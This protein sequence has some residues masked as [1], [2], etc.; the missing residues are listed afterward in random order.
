MQLRTRTLSMAALFLVT[1]CGGTTEESMHEEPSQMGLHTA[2]LELPGEAEAQ[3][4]LPTQSVLAHGCQ[5]TLEMARGFP[6]FLR[7]LIL[8]RRASPHCVAETVTLVE[9][10]PFLLPGGLVLAEK[11]NELVV[12]YRRIL[13]PTYN[14]A[15]LFIRHISPETLQT[16]RS[17]SISTYYKSGSITDASLEFHGH[18]LIVHGTKTGV[19]HGEPP[20]FHPRFTATYPSFFTSTEPPTIVLHD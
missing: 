5:Y 18:R 3:E 20:D 8:T 11:R 9:Q 10:S 2:A 13:H 1:A 19:F 14:I 6:P 15:A 4:S 12:A 17:V 7:S 16:I